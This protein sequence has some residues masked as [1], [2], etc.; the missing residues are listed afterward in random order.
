MKKHIPYI[1][2]IIILLIIN[3]IQ[4]KTKS[5]LKSESEIITTIDTLYIRDSIIITK[6]QYRDR[7]ITHHTVDT[8]YSVDSVLVPVHIPMETAIYSDSTTTYKYKA[9]VSGYKP[10]L[11]ELQVFTTTPTYNTTITKY[12]SYKWSISVGASYQP[13][14]N[15]I[16]PSINVGYNL[17]S[18]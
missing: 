2:V 1:L 9:V 6:P 11:D 17:F 10:S 13:I 16:Q 3:L 7:Y 18:W 5:N 14:S 8:L 12:K 15:T 4:F